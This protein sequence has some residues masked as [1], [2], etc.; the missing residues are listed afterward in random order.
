M[1]TRAVDLAQTKV[2]TGDDKPYARDQR[3]ETYEEIFDDMVAARRI[4]VRPDWRG[5][6]IRA[7]FANFLASDAAS[8]ITGVA[9]IIGGDS[10]PLF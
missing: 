6:G 8:Y 7:N 5:R 10:S 3:E 2:L 1:V 9:I 4:P